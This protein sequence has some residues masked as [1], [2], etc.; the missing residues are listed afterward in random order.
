LALVALADAA[1]A[2]AESGVCKGQAE[3]AGVVQAQRH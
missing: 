1:L 2:L 3:S